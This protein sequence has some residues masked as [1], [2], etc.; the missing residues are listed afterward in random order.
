MVSVGAAVDAYVS[1]EATVAG[2]LPVVWCKERKRLRKCE[3]VRGAE[4]AVDDPAVPSRA[5]LRNGDEWTV[6]SR[7]ARR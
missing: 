1:D 2:E 5:R 6:R 7:M 3:F 4:P